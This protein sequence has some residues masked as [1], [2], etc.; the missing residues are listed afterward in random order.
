MKYVVKIGS[1]EMIYIPSFKKK[2]MVQAFKVDR[3]DIQTH[4]QH[5]DIISL[6]LFFKIRKV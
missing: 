5:D 4:R 1:V 2:K 3:G 6:L